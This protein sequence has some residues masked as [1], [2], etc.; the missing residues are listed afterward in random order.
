VKELNKTIQD[1]KMEIE[2]IKK[3]KR[4][5]TQEIEKSREEIK[6]HICRHHQQ[7]TRHGKENLRGRR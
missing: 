4:E 3:P 6:S 5:T 1:L 7:N 2:T